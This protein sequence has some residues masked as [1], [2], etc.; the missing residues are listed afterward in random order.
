MHRGILL[1]K[2]NSAAAVKLSQKQPTVSFFYLF[3]DARIK[4]GLGTPH[5]FSE[6]KYFKSINSTFLEESVLRRIL[7][8]AKNVY[9]GWKKSHWDHFDQMITRWSFW[10]N[11][12]KKARNRKKWLRNKS[13]PFQFIYDKLSKC[14]YSLSFN[15]CRLFEEILQVL[16]TE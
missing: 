1:R 12:C 15:A 16:K 11:F 9:F 10:L 4:M 3:C 7:T 13:A 2:K 6:E 8:S 14:N 5:N